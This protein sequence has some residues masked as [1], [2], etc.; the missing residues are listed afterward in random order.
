MASPKHVCTRF[1][2]TNGLGDLAK[3][4]CVRNSV[5]EIW[6]EQGRMDTK[7]IKKM[8]YLLCTIVCES[9]CPITFLRFTE[10]V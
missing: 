2:E 5:T 6:E 7:L 3:P 10:G 8:Y 9:W 1:S 4:K